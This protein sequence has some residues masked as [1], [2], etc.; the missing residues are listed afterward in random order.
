MHVRNN[1]DICFVDSHEALPLLVPQRESQRNDSSLWTTY[2]VVQENLIE[3][4][5]TG[6]GVHEILRNEKL[7]HALWSDAQTL[8][9]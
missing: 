3:R 5:R 6:R 4:G 2:N 7:N 8:L 1:V 9:N